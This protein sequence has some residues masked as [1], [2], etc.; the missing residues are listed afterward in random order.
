MR[1]VLVFAAA[2]L[3]T[4][5]H[6]A[7][8]DDAIRQG[9]VC[10]AAN[11]RALARMNAGG[12]EAVTA[13]QDVSTGAVIAF[14]ASKPETFDV[15]AN[16]LPLSVIKVM[17]AA[18]WWEHGLAERTFTAE[19]PKP[20]EASVEDIIAIGSDSAG[21]ELARELRKA[22][23]T[24]GVVADFERY[25]FG[26]GEIW[27]E[28]APSLAKRLKRAV[29]VLTLKDDTGD[30][31]W[32]DALSI[33]EANLGLSP[34]HMSRFM[35][36]I[37]NDGVLLP[38][39]AREFKTG[40]V[41]LAAAKGERLVKETTAGKLQT[42]MK[43]TVTRGTATRIADALS[44]TGWTMGGKTGTGPGPMP[45]GPDS[46]GWFAGL[47]FDDK[48][49]A[50]FTVATYVKHGGFGGGNAA[51]ISATVARFL[52]DGGTAVEKKD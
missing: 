6:A 47:V 50:R 27:A 17:T 10:E 45:L 52:I 19:K 20:H 5:A 24:K 48:G 3:A 44:P 51:K 4:A 2:L 37:G 23:G 26:G 22:V 11:A 32:T 41:R 7:P 13:V 9:A 29:P 14:A 28:L 15:S 12:L 38:L 16:V 31:E 21:R 30:A 8:C 43:A 34:L 40:A 39:S 42:A 49:A 36:A 35:Q 46:D 25:A 33:G 1:S 18:S